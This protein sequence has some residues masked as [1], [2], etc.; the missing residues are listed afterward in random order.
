M[1]NLFA[2]LVAIVGS[3]GC[4]IP[5]FDTKPI[6]DRQIA[7]IRKSQDYVLPAQ[8]VPP[9]V[10]EP[11]DPLLD[12]VSAGYRVALAQGLIADASDALNG[13]L[14]VGQRVHGR[15]V[16]V[17]LS[18]FIEKD[19]RIGIEDAYS[20]KLGDASLGRSMRRKL[21]STLVTGK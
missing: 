3:V 14:V 8:S 19:G 13:I 17:L 18:F 20:W 7:L 1:R 15:Q 4:T 16:L 11:T 9:Y 2:L 21:I 10:T 5:S 12:A 6:S